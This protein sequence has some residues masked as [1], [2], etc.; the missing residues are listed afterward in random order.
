MTAAFEPLPAPK[1]SLGD[2][3]SI[4]RQVFETEAAKSI[5]M[6]G[7]PIGHDL[8][9]KIAGAITGAVAAVAMAPLV[10]PGAGATLAA[11]EM[12]VYLT[13][14]FAGIHIGGAAFEYLVG[15]HKDNP[16]S[17]ATIVS[18]VQKNTDHFITSRGGKATDAQREHLLICKI[19]LAMRQKPDDVRLHEAL[20]ILAES[21]DDLDS[22]AIV[23]VA[24]DRHVPTE[25]FEWNVHTL[26]DAITWPD[27]YLEDIKED[28][29]KPAVLLTTNYLRAELP[30]PA[31]PND[32]ARVMTVRAAMS[33]LLADYGGNVKGNEFERD[34]LT[35]A[36][37]GVAL[38]EMGKDD[39][40]YAS[41][42][43]VYDD[44]LAAPP[45]N[46]ATRYDALDEMFKRGDRTALDSAAKLYQGWVQWE[47]EPLSPAQVSGAFAAEIQRLLLFGDL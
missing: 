34:H 46:A 45:R 6:N 8:V 2:K 23:V 29:G 4:F 13:G 22:K 44:F 19:A 41:L 38:L 16:P 5:A 17:V 39:A 26:M 31:D 35:L 10:L 42:T 15:D 7:H 3:I 40:Q 47:K 11:A 1:K 28:G 30:P 33:D 9:G 25:M 27:D 20:Q 36:C 21:T 12:A 32:S 14:W 37:L 43:A 24:F 18:K